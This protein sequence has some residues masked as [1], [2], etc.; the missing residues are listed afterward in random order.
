MPAVNFI[1]T[2]SFHW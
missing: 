1:I 2:L